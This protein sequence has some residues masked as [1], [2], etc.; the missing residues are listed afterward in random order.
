MEIG[1][2]VIEAGKLRVFVDYAEVSELSD[3]ERFTGKA[4]SFGILPE[5]AFDLR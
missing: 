1:R 2:V 4:A 3:P 5:T